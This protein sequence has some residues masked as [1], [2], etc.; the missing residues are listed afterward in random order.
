MRNVLGQGAPQFANSRCEMQ[1][2]RGALV[3]VRWRSR[4]SAVGHGDCPQIAPN[5]GEAARAHNRAGASLVH[6]P[7][8]LTRPKLSGDLCLIEVNPLRDDRSGLYRYR[9]H[10]RHGECP[11]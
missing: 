4:E 1:L 11:T 6:S 3:S 7:A 2:A 10:E 9:R 8:A 5:F